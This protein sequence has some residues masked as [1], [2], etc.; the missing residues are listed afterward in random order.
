MF[1]FIARAFGIPTPVTCANR[2]LWAAHK[3]AA[4]AANDK[5]LIAALRQAE[6]RASEAIA[7]MYGSAALT[8]PTDKQLDELCEIALRMIPELVTSPE[9]REAFDS[10]LTTAPATTG[11][12]R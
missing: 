4:F 2:A 3:A 6:E 11:K 1:K 10:A 8:F 12:Q 5:R 7:E 9:V